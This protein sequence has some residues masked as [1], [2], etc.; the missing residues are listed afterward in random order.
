M[1]TFFPPV[2]LPPLLLLPLFLPKPFVDNLNSLWIQVPRLEITQKEKLFSSP[3]NPKIRIP[4]IESLKQS[5]KIKTLIKWGSKL[6]G[7]WYSE[8]CLKVLNFASKL[9]V[10]L[11]Y[12]NFFFS[13]FC[14][15][16]R[17][18]E[19]S[20]LT[21]SY[22]TQFL[23][24]ELHLESAHKTTVP[25]FPPSN[26]EP[27]CGIFFHHHTFSTTGR[28]RRAAWRPNHTQPFLHKKISETQ[29]CKSQKFL[30]TIINYPPHNTIPTSWYKC[31][32]SLSSGSPISSIPNHT[33]TRTVKRPAW[34]N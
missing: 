18:F 20:L 9:R 13:K 31:W 5:P 33:E 22:H 34:D 17:S 28:G 7:S 16:L 10:L 1:Q 32:Y 11:Q 4:S 27:E 3:R 12:F 25:P 23:I 2:S 19:F 8:G 24:T 6:T 30:Y 29:S 15:L 14:P 26:L 21:Q